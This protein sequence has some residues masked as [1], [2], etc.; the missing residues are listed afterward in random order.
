MGFDG[1]YPEVLCS[2]N[3]DKL[4]EGFFFPLAS[5]GRKI[6]SGRDGAVL[7]VRDS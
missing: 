1:S 7:A 2:S 5:D 6:N 4:L 3:V